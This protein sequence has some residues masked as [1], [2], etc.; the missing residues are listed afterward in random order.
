MDR[1]PKG[2]SAWQNISMLRAMAMQKNIMTDVSG[3]GHAEA[4]FLDM[5]EGDG[6]L[7]EIKLAL[8]SESLWGNIGKT[9]IAMD[10]MMAGK[11]NPLHVFGGEKIE[12][13]DDLVKM[14]EAARAAQKKA[15]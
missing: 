15:K 11:M 12:G 7:N 4:F 14:V 13:H 1:C 9:G 2:I 3:P 6:R 10:L 8:R 5:V